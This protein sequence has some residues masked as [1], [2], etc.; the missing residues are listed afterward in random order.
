MPGIMP[1]MHAK[2]RGMRTLGAIG[3]A[4][5]MVLLFCMLLAFAGAT[6]PTNGLALALALALVPVPFVLRL[7]LWLDRFEPEPLRALA[8]AF[9]WGA[10]FA[11]FVALVVNSVGEAIV[12]ESLGQDAGTLYGGSISAPV[13]EESA[14]GFALLMIFRRRLV[15]GVLDGIVYAT[16][17]GLGFAF[18]ENVFYYAQGAAEQGVEGAVGTFVLRGLMSPLA[19]PLF[20]SM[21]GIGLGIAAATRFGVL[22]AL[23]PVVGLALAMVLHS[24][25]NTGAATGLFFGVYLLV[26]APML[27]AI[28]AVALWQRR[29]EMAAIRCHLEPLVAAG[30]L[31]RSDVQVLASARGRRQIT[32]QA[33]RRRRRALQDFADA[34][35]A[36]AFLRERQQRR[37]E[38]PDPAAER[39]ALQRLL[40][41]RSAALT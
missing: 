27:L 30:T 13:V 40:A 21:F 1:A 10:T 35:T 6:G 9:A 29:R 25:W 18:T 31:A 22:R 7:V 38:R 33:D 11:C 19:H 24:L 37:R 3:L 12:S 2:R 36:F 32:A 4:G 28:G 15:D 16:L 14:K 5:T 17:V 39:A 20:T 26:F 34:A 23:A 41:A 8:F